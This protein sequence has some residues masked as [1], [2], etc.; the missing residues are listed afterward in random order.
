MLLYKG[1]ITDSHTK[2]IQCHYL[3]TLTA[4]TISNGCNRR[5]KLFKYGTIGIFHI[6]FDAVFFPF[7]CINLE[8]MC[9]ICIFGWALQ[10]HQ[11]FCCPSLEKATKKK[12]SRNIQCGDCE[13]WIYMQIKSKIICYVCWIE[14]RCPKM[15]C[16]PYSMG[17]VQYLN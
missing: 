12:Y 16:I 8:K 3:T 17:H 2:H 9:L 4:H 10:F 11:I 7:I 5:K 13:N 15:K 6:D 1:L 14:S